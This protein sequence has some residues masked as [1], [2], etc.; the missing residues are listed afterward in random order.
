MMYNR[1]RRWEGG[2]ELIILYTSPG[3]AS[4]RKAKQWL[5]EH[6]LAFVEKNIF[7]TILNKDEIKYL[8]NRSENGT[9]D[10][11][12]TRSKA[13]KQ[14]GEDVDS[15]SI[16][17]L[18]SFVQQNPSVLKRPILIDDKSMVIGYD[19]DEITSFIPSEARNVLKDA[20]NERCPSYKYCGAVR[21]LER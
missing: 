2:V 7:S 15:L 21:R 10:L 3:C 17:S 11:I 20:C 12:S 5:K 6:D 8:L 9:E 19:D 18:I 16:N 1:S 4:C 13:F 14:L